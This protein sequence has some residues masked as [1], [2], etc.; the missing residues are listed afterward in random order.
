[1]TSRLSGGSDGQA[2]GRARQTSWRAGCFALLAP[3]AR[4]AAIA[5]VAAGLHVAGDLEVAQGGARGGTG[6][7][8]SEP[9]VLSR[10][11]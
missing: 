3:V 5:G 1:M 11:A 10:R 2:R 4:V 8:A 6:R 9:V 7:A